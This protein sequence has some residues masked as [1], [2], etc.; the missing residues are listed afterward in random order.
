MSESYDSQI[1]IGDDESFLNIEKKRR[2]VGRKRLISRKTFLEAVKRTLSISDKYI[3]KV[4][5]VD[6]TTVYRFK[7]A[8]PNV[9]REA[10]IYLEQISVLDLSPKLMFYDNVENIPTIA[11]FKE[12]MIRRMIGQRKIQTRARL[13]RIVWRLLIGIMSYQP[14]SL[15]GNQPLY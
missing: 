9:L 10:E 5:G 7:K 1:T 3:S 2:K 13:L 12:T 6:R 4:L 11:R 8:N 14:L 15:D